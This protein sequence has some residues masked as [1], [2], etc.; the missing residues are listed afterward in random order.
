MDGELNEMVQAPEPG[1]EYV[2][3]VADE[4]A[5]HKEVKV[6]ALQK[7]E[8]KNAAEEE[9]ARRK[10]E[11]EVQ[12][13]A[14]QKEALR[15]AKEE[16][17]R[18]R[19]A[20]EEASRKAAEEAQRKAVEQEAARL[21]AAAAEALKKAAEEEAQRKAAEEEVERKAAEDE[22]RL[23]GAEEAEAARLEAIKDAERAQRRADAAADRAEMDQV[24]V[25]TFLECVKP[26]T[27]RDNVRTPLKGTN[28]Y[29]RHM[30]PARAAG[31]SV[32]IKDSSFLNLGAFLKFLQ[33][34]GLLCLKEGVSD[35]VV[36]KIYHE[37]CRNYEYAQPSHTETTP[38]KAEPKFSWQ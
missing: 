36:T 26:C 28:L 12:K 14:A 6:K 32:D 37:A 3:T 18:K 7:V 21:K 13:R 10:A 9:K 33:G 31:T 27:W 25:E 2:K 11:E 5:R 23:K 15:K 1:E 8:E 4:V 19:A 17:S 34:E 35:P 30:R 16:E 29:T 22:A 38:S 20:E 24:C